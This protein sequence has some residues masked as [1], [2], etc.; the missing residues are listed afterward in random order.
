[1]KKNYEIAGMSCGGCVNS[2][3][4]ALLQVPD[5]ENV[6]VQLNPPSAVI[7]MNRSIELDQLQAQLNKT[8]HYSIKELI[9]L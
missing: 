7:I 9:S 2:V 5:V 1:M 8:G 4:K 3:K 6:E